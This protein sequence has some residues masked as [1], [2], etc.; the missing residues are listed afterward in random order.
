MPQTTN[1]GLPYPDST[2]PA[3]VPSDIQALA[4]KLDTSI[5]GYWISPSNVPP[6][7]IYAGLLWYQ[8]N[9]GYSYLYASSSTSYLISRTQ[10]VNAKPY[11]NLYIATAMNLNTTVKDIRFDTIKTSL[12]GSYVPTLDTGSTTPGRVTVKKDGVYQIN[13]TVTSNSTVNVLS[14]IVA[15]GTTYN[16]IYQGASTYG[17][18]SASATVAMNNGDVVYLQARADNTGAVSTGNST[19]SPT[20]MQITY[21]GPLA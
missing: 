21:L 10:E 7:S 8:T 4:A 16:G 19:S 2:Y 9:T 13:G 12:G 17:S 5:T 6:P 1:L 15:S 3:N 14:Q 11:I 20:F 18:S